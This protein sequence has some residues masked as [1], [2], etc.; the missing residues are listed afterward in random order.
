MRLS[1]VAVVFSALAVCN[2]A[3]AQVDDDGRADTDDW[4]DLAAWHDDWYSKFPDRNSVGL[5]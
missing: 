5:H 2:A 3:M 4:R 1:L